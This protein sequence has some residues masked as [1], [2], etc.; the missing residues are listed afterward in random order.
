MDT[1]RDR[2]RA[3]T[4][5]EIT[6]TARRILVEQGPSAVTL[7]AIAREMGMTAPGLYRYFAS[8]AELVRHL[9]GELLTEVT[10]AMVDAMHALPDPDMSAKFL[11]VSREFRR[12]SLAHP[13]EFT[14]VYGAPLPP[15][16]RP[17]EPDAATEQ[18]R[19]FGWV[20]LELFLELWSKAP[21]PIPSDDE[22]TPSLRDQLTE[23]RTRVA[24]TDVPLGLLQL[25]LECWARLEGAVSLEVFGHLDFALQDPSPMFELMLQDVAP[26]LHLTYHPE[27]P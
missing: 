9:V 14:L 15:L 23:Y 6:R 2:R 5:E 20:F 4:V 24:L 22:I 19:R 18:G 27:T 13:Q 8:H 10:A 16:G 17:D 1:R 12:W 25:F 21:F 26:R 3:A 11:T 7:R